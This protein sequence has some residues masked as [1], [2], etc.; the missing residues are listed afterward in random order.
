MSRLASLL[1]VV[2][3][4][5]AVSCSSQSEF[6]PKPVDPIPTEN[7]SFVKGADVSWLPLM[8][9]NGYLFLAQNETTKDGLQFLKDRRNTT[10]C[11]CVGGNS[12][13][14]KIDRQCIKDEI[15]AI[16]VLAKKWICV[17]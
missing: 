13:N 2:M 11:L 12:S 14:H 3:L 16:A 17:L 7:P 9:V 10:V 15:I 1:L 6:M 4:L 8:D 5:I